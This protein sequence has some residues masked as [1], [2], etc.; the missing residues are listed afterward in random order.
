M[1]CN[2]IHAILREKNFRANVLKLKN[3]TF[4]TKLLFHENAR[5][6]SMCGAMRKWRHSLAGNSELRKLVSQAGPAEV[7]LNLGSASTGGNKST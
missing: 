7:M 2:Y 5:D 1:F 3:T 4:E 6:M